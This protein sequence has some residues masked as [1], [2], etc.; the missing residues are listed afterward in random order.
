MRKPMTTSEKYKKGYS[1]IELNSKSM[2]SKI[3][4]SNPYKKIQCNK[5]VFRLSSNRKDVSFSI[6]VFYR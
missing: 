4:K 6:Y 1:N 3:I 2:E 5:N